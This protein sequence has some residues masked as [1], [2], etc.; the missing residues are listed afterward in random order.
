MSLIHFDG[1]DDYRPHTSSNVSGDSAMNGALL[2]AGYS[3]AY[4]TR[5]ENANPIGQGR[6]L[7]CINTSGTTS[8]SGLRKPI[9]DVAKPIVGFHMLMPNDGTRSRIC[10][11]KNGNLLGGVTDDIMLIMNEQRGITLTNTG[12][13]TVY[14]AS[15]GSIVFPGVWYFLEIMADYATKQ[16][17][18]RLNED[19][20]IP[21]AP[22]PSAR[23]TVNL[24]D[25]MGRDS[26]SA[27]AKLY[28][29]L[30]I[31]DGATGGA[32]FTDFLG[33]IAVITS[34]P[35]ADTVANEMTV[36]GSAEPEHYKVVDDD[37]SN[38]A[39]YLSADTEGL[40][41][42]FSVTDLPIDTLAVYAVAAAPRL[43]KG[44]G[45]AR[46]RTM[47]RIGDSGTPH[48]NDD[49]SSSAAFSTVLDIMSERPGGG[50]WT[51]ED[52]NDLQIGFET[53]P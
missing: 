25:F 48:I 15:E 7:A 30:Y 16:C 35:D 10:G 31:L 34:R 27:T 24:F 50:T 52:V 33:E 38:D 42:W 9:G 4:F 11:F 39:D 3:N 18:V 45:P 43:R 40:E 37:F 44:A 8:F 47:V 12:M 32:P 22:F 1:F 21:A 19:T 51:V 6:S 5:A 36:N 13:S 28:D 23:T 26:F 41:E 20:I 2:S 53:R 49:R 17:T 29:N 46:Y 14:A